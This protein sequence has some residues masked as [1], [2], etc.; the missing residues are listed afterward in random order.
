MF[1][2]KRMLDVLCGVDISA[3]PGFASAVSMS[4]MAPQVIDL[5]RHVMIRP[6]VDTA[7]G[8]IVNIQQ[9]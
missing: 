7:C 6:T 1:S 3:R 8:Q 9:V 2:C 4:D 5:G